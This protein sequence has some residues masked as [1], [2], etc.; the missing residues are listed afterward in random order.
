MVVSATHVSPPVPLTEPE[1]G[2]NYAF[3]VVMTGRR[4]TDSK[5]NAAKTVS[6]SAPPGAA[7]G[8]QSQPSGPHTHYRHTLARV[9]RAAFW[10]VRRPPAWWPGAKKW[11]GGGWV[12]RLGAGGAGHGRPTPILY[13]KY[14]LYRNFAYT[15][16][17]KQL[18]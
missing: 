7:G 2:R 1:L 12:E 3:Q 11:E 8:R 10:P 17:F 18:Y 14:S 13:F 15:L 9:Q 6:V 5:V 4:R 16:V